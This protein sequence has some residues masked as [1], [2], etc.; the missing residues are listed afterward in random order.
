MNE[1]NLIQRVD[2]A[3]GTLEII[4]DWISIAANSRYRNDSNEMKKIMSNGMT[5]KVGNVETT[6]FDIK[7]Y[8]K[9]GK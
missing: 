9:G 7:E 2:E 1:I 8:L 4:S 3:I 5:N 6:L